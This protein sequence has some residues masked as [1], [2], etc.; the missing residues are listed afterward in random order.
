[1][2]KILLISFLSLITLSSCSFGNL[3]SS[4]KNENGSGSP[5]V[6]TPAKVENGKLV[7]LHYTLR[8]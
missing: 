1:M 4:E 3:S 6:I 2:K 5:L 8:E 7:T